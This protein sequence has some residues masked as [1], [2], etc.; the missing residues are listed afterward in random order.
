MTLS[1]EIERITELDDQEFTDE[2][3]D[4]IWDDREFEIFLEVELVDRTNRLLG[5]LSGSITS[6]LAGRIDPPPG[7]RSRAKSLL[8]RVN[9]RKSEAKLVISDLNRKETATV[10]AY[11]RKWSIRLFKLAEALES[12]GHREVLNEI[13][14]D[15]DGGITA[16]EWLD[17]RRKRDARKLEKQVGESE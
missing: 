9:S 10:D 16:G 11:E 7:W 8:V 3:L 6:Q 1:N 14:L 2:L 17:W 12:L 15:D 4:A 5:A 13:A